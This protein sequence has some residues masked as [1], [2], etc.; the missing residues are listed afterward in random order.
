MENGCDVEQYIEEICVQAAQEVWSWQKGLTG[1]WAMQW[2]QDQL[3][4]YRPVIP[5]SDQAG[6]MAAFANAL[7]G[8]DKL[9]FWDAADIIAS[10]IIS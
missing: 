4:K 3:A 2:W 5:G 6:M 7:S 1:A 10:S 9:G 8:L